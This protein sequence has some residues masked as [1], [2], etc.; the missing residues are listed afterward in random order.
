MHY[1][2]TVLSKEGQDIKEQLAPFQENNEGDCPKEYL[3]FVSV[4]EKEK[5][6]YENDIVE[7][8]KLA[9]GS[10]VS[11]WD[12][13]LFR[14]I[15]KEE[16]EEYEK[17]DKPCS[18]LYHSNIADKPFYG[19]RDLEH[20]GA[21]KVEIPYKELY[22]T[23]EEYMKKTSS[24][25]FDEEMQDYGYWENP[26]AKWDWYLIGGRWSDRLV[27]K[28]GVTGKKGEPSLI[29]S[30]TLSADNTYSSLKIK[31]IDWEHIKMKDF[32]SYGV[33][34]PD[35]IWK[36][37]KD[38]ESHKKWYELINSDNSSDYAERRKLRDKSAEEWKEMYQEI[39]SK[40]DPEWTLTV[41][42][43]HI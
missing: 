6:I 25:K 19:I 41:V 37:E 39:M 27:A 15:T 26:N 23:F 13:C 29:C 21:V 40:A 35:G 12:D 4:T 18:C 3:E 9:D 33:L 16:Y 32:K 36:D 24:R 30:Y 7:R 43:I 31:D 17:Q 5:K 1:L 11:P 20:I 42:D 8:V 38:T 22:P 2:I 14:E 28:D 34:T 10:L